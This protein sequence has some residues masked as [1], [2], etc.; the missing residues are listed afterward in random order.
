MTHPAGTRSSPQCEKENTQGGVDEKDTVTLASSTE[1]LG[2]S[3][4][5]HVENA[6]DETVKENFGQEEQVCDKVAQSADCASSADDS[7]RDQ[8]RIN[9]ERAEAYDDANSVECL[10]RGDLDVDKDDFADWRPEDEQIADEQADAKKDPTRSVE[11][12]DVDKNTSSRKSFKS[13]SIELLMEEDDEGHQVCTLKSLRH[14]RD[15]DQIGENEGYGIRKTKI[16][17]GAAEA[18]FVVGKQGRTK[19]KLAK[20]SGAKVSLSPGLDVE[21]TGTPSQRDRAEFYLKLIVQ[22][23]RGRVYIAFD[24]CDRDDVT[25]VNV[26]ENSVAFITGQAGSTLRAIEEEYN[27]LMF[28]VQYAK[29]HRKTEAAESEE[30]PVE[31]LLI[32]GSERGRKC[33]ELKVQSAI[34]QKNPDRY[35]SNHFGPDTEKLSGANGF[36]LDWFLIPTTDFSYALGKDGS[37]RRR[38]A[39]AARCTLEYV[40]NYAVFAGEKEDRRRCRDYLRWLCESRTSANLNLNVNGRNDVTIVSIPGEFAQALNSNSLRWVE[41]STSTLCLLDTA[42][43]RPRV[44]IL[45]HN[46][47]SR[48]QAVKH[49]WKLLDNLSVSQDF[50]PEYFYEAPARSEP[51]LKETRPL[52]DFSQANDFL[53]GRRRKRN[54]GPRRNND[55]ENFSANPDWAR[56]VTEVG[57]NALHRHEFLPPMAMEHNLEPNRHHMETGPSDY[58]WRALRTDPMVARR[59]AHY[60]KWERNGVRDG[61]EETRSLSPRGVI[62]MRSHEANRDREMLRGRNAQVGARRTGACP[63][64]S[65][66]VPDERLGVMPGVPDPR[67]FERLR[68]PSWADAELSKRR[69]TSRSF[70]DRQLRHRDGKGRTF[71]EGVDE[72]GDG[73]WTGQVREGTRQYISGSTHSRNAQTSR[74]MNNIYNRPEEDRARMRPKW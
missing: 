56:K 4:R 23:K 41:A 13:V 15:A 52:S 27:T 55:M 34:A 33:S 73:R 58:S 39:R 19:Q 16:R 44:Y 6:D 21:I 3:T 59:N 61:R 49:L 2:S 45:A 36:D 43:E 32:F 8:S 17:I 38:L 72:R 1:N 29:D 10:E 28:M 69:R 25:F 26:P 14:M 24:E 40:G 74:P 37:T 51:R 60:N 31:P 71:A 66:P 42:G 70:E 47:R 64:M 48:E 20:V 22:Q 68:C 12:E 11:N 63:S 5:T 54:L 30:H 53:G 7:G 18:A 67:S 57:R 9:H 35:G 46:N 50:P 65:M 62:E